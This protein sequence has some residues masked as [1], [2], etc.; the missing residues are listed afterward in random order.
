VK[1][2]IC[3]MVVLAIVLFALHRKNI[4]NFNLQFMGA[5]VQL[6]ARDHP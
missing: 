5:R 6:E 1:G 3:V 4:V 2:F